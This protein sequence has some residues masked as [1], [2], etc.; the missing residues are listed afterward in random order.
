[1]IVISKIRNRELQ[2]PSH[3]KAFSYGVARRLSLSARRVRVEDLLSNRE[4][5]EFPSS[6]VTVLAAIAR[7]ALVC[8]VQGAL[9]KLRTRDRDL[10]L[11]RYY[12][13]QS[14]VQIAESLRLTVGGTKAALN[15]AR[16]RLKNVLDQ[17]NLEL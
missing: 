17:A 13:E 3:I 9:A 11:R 15:R 12:Y 1:M 4:P 7:S 6:E 10:I 2:N 14:L 8:A 16:A 5:D